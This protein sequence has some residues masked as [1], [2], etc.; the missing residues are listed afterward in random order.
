M[1]HECIL[2]LNLLTLYTFYMPIGASI[3][4]FNF[5]I[6][7][8]LFYIFGPSLYTLFM[9]LLVHL[10]KIFYCLWPVYVYSLSMYVFPLAQTPFFPQLIS[11]HWP[12]YANQLV[13]DHQSRGPFNRIHCSLM[14]TFTPPPLPFILL[15]NDNLEN[16]EKKNV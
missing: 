6:W 4:N 11:M 3:Y 14:G 13:T 5:H 2:Y 8:I 1:A 15:L 16:L 7:L 12:E 9:R 10:C